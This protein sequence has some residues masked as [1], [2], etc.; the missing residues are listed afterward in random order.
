[1][2]AESDAFEQLN[3]R[4]RKLVDGRTAK[5]TWNAHIPDPDSPN[6]PRQ[7]DVLLEEGGRR[8][9]VECRDRDSSQSVKVKELQRLLGKKTLENEML[10]EAVGVARATK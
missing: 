1:M 7:I 10:R 3:A 4:I 2:T 8:T 5:V 6:V 9:A